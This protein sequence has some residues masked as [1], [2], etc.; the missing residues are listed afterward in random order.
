MRNDDRNFMIMALCLV[1]AGLFSLYFYFID[2]KKTDTVFVKNFP[3]T[4]GAWVSEE[5]PLS[6]G[7]LALLETDNA[8][9]RRYSNP[10]GEE[11]YLY[12]VY[13][14]NN[15]KITHLPEVCY[16]GKGVSFLEEKQ[17][18]IPVNYQ[19]LT[20]SANR[21]LLQ[22]GKLY[23]ICFYWFKAGDHFTSDYWKEKIF[24][25]LNTFS[26]QRRG[27]ALIRISA[28]VNKND[29]ET[30]IKEVKEFTNLI[31]AQ[32]FGYLP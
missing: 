15:D 18:F 25:A 7:D 10:D 26:G 29:K 22:A 21:L 31:A 4:V 5:I 17:D 13:S 28:A 32:L 2:L 27:N 12:I 16:R 19:H 11:V 23:Q 8:F 20:I 1:T 9:F 30:A 6:K 3:R 14:Q 24:I